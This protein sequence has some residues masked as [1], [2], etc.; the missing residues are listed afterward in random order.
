M[1]TGAQRAVCGHEGP[2]REA[3][4]EVRLNPAR[5]ITRP[6]QQ[7]LSGVS[8]GHAAQKADTAD[9]RPEGSV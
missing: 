7:Q 4:P 1:R 2:G 3:I 5:R 6:N 9:T 8:R